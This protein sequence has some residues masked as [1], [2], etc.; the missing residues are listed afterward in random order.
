MIYL[1]I[2]IYL[3]AGYSYLSG[4]LEMEMI[5]EEVNG[6]TEKL[7][8]EIKPLS[9]PLKDKWILRLTV[10]AIWPILVIAG[11]VLKLRT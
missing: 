5:S 1:L 3:L 4:M 10:V 7:D 8:K 6:V 2:A 9:T 11:I